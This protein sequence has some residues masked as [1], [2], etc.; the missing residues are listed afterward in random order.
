MI[1][2]PSS[3][4]EAIADEICARLI[5]GE[6][7]RSICKS[8]HM[9]SAGTVCRW[10]ADARYAVFREQYTRAKEIQLDVLADEIIHIA[11]TQEVGEIV[12]EKPT[13][14]EV[15]RAD[16]IEHRR[17]KID[18]RKWYVGKL[19]PKKYGDRTQ[20]EHTGTDGGPV[21]LVVMTGVPRGD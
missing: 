6:S 19:A 15:K 2:R 9:P 18:A 14:T 7:L 3:Y 20:L 1:G 11:N 16:M 8:D 10:L 17:L 12:T 13:G 5:E 4:T 21:Q